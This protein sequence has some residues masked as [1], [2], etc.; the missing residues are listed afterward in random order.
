MSVMCK[1]CREPAIVQ[2]EIETIA[3][4]LTHAIDRHICPCGHAAAWC[5]V[6]GCG[7][8]QPLTDDD[9]QLLLY[10]WQVHT[11]DPN[12]RKFH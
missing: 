8:W 12:E 7:N 11:T 5:A 3:L 1:H 10:E 2:N 6:L 4:C 9:L